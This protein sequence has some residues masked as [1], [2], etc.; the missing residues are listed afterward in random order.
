MPK[1]CWNWPHCACGVDKARE[2]EAGGGKLLVYRDDTGNVRRVPTSELKTFAT[3]E[4]IKAENYSAGC[5]KARGGSDA[6]A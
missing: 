6:S 1:W 4:G 3:V 2:V 5:P